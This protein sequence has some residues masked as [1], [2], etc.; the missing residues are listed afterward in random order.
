[1][2]GAA[3]RLL[4]TRAGPKVALE[5]QADVRLHESGGRPRSVIRRGFFAPRSRTRGRRWPNRW[6]RGPVNR[7]G[8]VALSRSLRGAQGRIGHLA[9]VLGDGTRRKTR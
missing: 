2:I 9:H 8:T 3:V 4:G 5:R 6:V 7:A 1:M